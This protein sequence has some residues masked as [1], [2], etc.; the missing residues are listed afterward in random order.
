MVLDVCMNSSIE[1]VKLFAAD[2]LFDIIATSKQD[3]G[4]VSKLKGKS[5]E[6]RQLTFSRNSEIKMKEILNKY[7]DRIVLEVIA[8]FRSVNKNL[9]ML[10]YLETFIGGGEGKK[11]NGGGITSREINDMKLKFSK[12]TTWGEILRI[13]RDQMTQE[14]FSKILTDLLILVRQGSDSVIK[15]SAVSFINDIILEQKDIISAKDSKAIAVKM[16]ENLKNNGPVMKES[17]SAIIAQCLGLQMKLLR[18][19]TKTISLLL[20]AVLQIS[21]DQIYLGLLC[22]TEIHKNIPEADLRENQNSYVFPFVGLFYMSKFV[23]N[24]S[25]LRAL[26]KSWF[27]KTKEENK[28]VLQMNCQA[29][30]KIITEY[31]D[32][33]SYEDRFAASEALTDFIEN[34][35]T[36]DFMADKESCDLL[37][38][39]L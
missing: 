16:I 12:D 5:K 10:N 11:N 31:F 1:Q 29:V 14:T 13:C 36:V 7:L 2:L 8:N 32:S 33:N 3:S 28:H 17:N 26:S 19:Y 27:E 21:K 30:V 38:D 9:G 20:Q 15:A 18:P 23:I 6:E 35:N 22:V 37:V 25:K 39:T 24:N 4:V 34:V